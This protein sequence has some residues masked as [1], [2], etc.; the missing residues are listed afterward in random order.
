MPERPWSECNRGKAMTQNL[1]AKR[2]KP[3]GIWPKKVGPEVSGYA[4]ESFADS[5]VRYIPSRANGQSD[6]SNEINNLDAKQNGQT[7]NGC[8]V[9][10]GANSLNL[11]GLSGCPDANAILAD[12]GESA[13][14][15]GEDSAPPIWKGRI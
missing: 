8:P 14:G 7:K 4:L 6:K 15:N 12:E 2:L 1:L 5:F 13:S 9:A 10:N 3:F 11:N